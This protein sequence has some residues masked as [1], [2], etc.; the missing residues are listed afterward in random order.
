MAAG[1]APMMVA[2]SD[3]GGMPSAAVARLISSRPMPHH[4]TRSEPLLAI[5]IRNP[6]WDR[7]HPAAPDLERLLAGPAGVACVAPD[8]DVRVLIVISGA[9][10]EI[11]AAVRRL[12]AG[13]LPAGVC[14]VPLR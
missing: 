2:A 3:H 14:R 4:P 7:D 1:A 11:R 9:P 5:A 8:A 10:A 12:H 13:A 6:D